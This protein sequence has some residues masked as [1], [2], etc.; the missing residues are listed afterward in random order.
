[1][2]FIPINFT[3]T[4]WTPTNFAYA[5]WARKNFLAAGLVLAALGS[6]AGRVAVAAT[7][8]SSQ[9]DQQ[10]C[11]A[12]AG[13]RFEFP[14]DHFSHACF[15][16]EWWYFT[17]NLGSADGRHFGFE[18]T[19]FREGIHNPYPNPSRWRVDQLYVAHFAISD[20]DKQKFFYTERLNR[21][22][23]GLAGASQ[24]E[25]RIWNGEWFAHWQ[26][27]R[28]TLQ[29][30]EQGHRIRLDLEP[31]KG[32]VIQGRDG[33]SQKADG[34]G[35]ASHYYS[36]TRLQASGEL[37]I[38]GKLY[39]VAGWS[40]MDHEFST[41]QLQPTQVGWDWVC[42]QMED[43]TEWMLFQLRLKDGG[44]DP[45]SAGSFVDRDGQVELLAAGDFQ[46]L[47]Q[48]RPQNH[49]RSPRTGAIYPIEWRIVV[50]RLGLDVKI[51]AAMPD[52][53]LVTEKTSGVIYWEGS[54]RA[55]GLRSGKPVTGKGYLEMTGYAGSLSP[56]LY[57]PVP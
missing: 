18:L 5:N 36:L 50:P 23:I 46:M 54:V 4:N 25:G 42:L 41:S 21:A 43:G 6:V 53:E 22:G 44:R 52:Q 26:G 47:P 37:E 39:T 27:N 20:I 56:G 48:G 7:E 33:V 12:L 1:M 55:E 2:N 32:P 9:A 13:Y 51:M 40:W 14:R 30:A 19:F 34:E 38:A 3:F 31:L 35:D 49:W 28:W 15:Q 10:F 11:R 8:P 57:A 17:G 16:T 45:H 24:G 29:A